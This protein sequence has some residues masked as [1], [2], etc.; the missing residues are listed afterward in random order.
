MRTLIVLCVAPLAALTACN[1]NWRQFDPV[2][3]S[4]P[5]DAGCD[6]PCNAPSVVLTGEPQCVQAG[7]S[8]TLRW[9]TEG[10]DHCTASGAWKGARPTGKG[11]V[12]I[13][14]PAATGVYTLQCEGPGGIGSA[15]V[16]VFVDPGVDAG[17]ALRVPYA[18]ITIDG[19][20]GDWARVGDQPVSQPW[21][22]CNSDCSCDA[23]CAAGLSRPSATDLSARFALAWNAKHLYVLGNVQDNNRGVP[24]DGGINPEQTDG[25]EIMINGRDDPPSYRGDGGLAIFGLDDHKLDVFPNGQTS[26]YNEVPPAGDFVAAACPS[27]GYYEVEVGLGL[28]WLLDQ[29]DY[30]P[31]PGTRYGFDLAV[32]DNDGL[33]CRD[34]VVM[35]QCADHY[36]YDTSSYGQIVLV[37]R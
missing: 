2:D 29:P 15:S 10:A 21:Q 1:W 20:A 16:P 7:E 30:L 12:A 37:C 34:D 31:R 35:W 4:T 3:A 33:A 24:L 5:S 8:V 28:G 6:G 11:Q 23:G 17:G 36:W 13:D 26:A 14:T 32:R 25:I 22:H 9:S 19:D 18:N 27:G